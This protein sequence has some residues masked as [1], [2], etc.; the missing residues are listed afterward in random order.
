MQQVRSLANTLA[1][2]VTRALVALA[3]G[4]SNTTELGRQIEP[5]NQE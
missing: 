2:V 3:A 4:E 5:T 1:A